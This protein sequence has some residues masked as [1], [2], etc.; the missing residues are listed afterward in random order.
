[1]CKI[2]NAWIVVLMTCFLA[3]ANA[4][5]IVD[6]DDLPIDVSEFK[7]H[8]AGMV[9]KK[10][11]LNSSNPAKV[12]E[13][14]AMSESSAFFLRFAA[15]G[16]RTFMIPPP[17]VETAVIQTAYAYAKGLGIQKNAVKIDE[18]VDAKLGGAGS[19]MFVRWS[20][21]AK[22]DQCSVTY[23]LLRPK[24]DGFQKI[25]NFILCGNSSSLPNDSRMIEILE[26]MSKS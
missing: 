25:G 16:S 19:A 22:V 11:P 4:E 15:T 13:Y 6:C 26:V 20:S 23:F 8:V 14:I 12:R 3:H 10:V 1:M 2:L 9:C 7:N 17:S 5:E 21:A 24:H 18:P